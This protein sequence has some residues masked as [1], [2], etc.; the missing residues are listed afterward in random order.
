LSD[1]NIGCASETSGTALTY[2][3]FIAAEYR[4]TLPGEGVLAKEIDRTRRQLDAER[5]S[6]SAA[7]QRRKR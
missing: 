6:S 2:F 5:P 3:S 7:R 4:T 1:A